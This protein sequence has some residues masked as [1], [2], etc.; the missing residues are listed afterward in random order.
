MSD[1]LKRNFRKAGKDYRSAPFW[2]WNGRMAPGEVRRQVRDMKAHGMGGFFMHSRVGLETEYMSDEWMRAI[3]AAVDEAAKIGMNAWLY[4]EDR[5]PTGAAGGLG[6]SGQH[7][8]YRADTSAHRRPRS[9]GLVPRRGATDD[10]G[11]RFEDGFIHWEGDPI[12][13]ANCNKP[14]PSEHGPVEEEE[15]K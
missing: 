6:H 4:D 7:N 2:S 9:A 3:E 11:W 1:T 13:C 8:R 14:L 15:K 10:P 12:I 5:W